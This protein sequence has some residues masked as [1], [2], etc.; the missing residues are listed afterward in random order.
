MT[1]SPEDESRARELAETG[2]TITSDL[3]GD[4]V[5]EIARLRGDNDPRKRR[6]APS[7]CESCAADFVYEVGEEC[8]HTCFSCLSKL[9]GDRR[10]S[11][12]RALD[13]RVGDLEHRLIEANS[14]SGSLE[15]DVQHLQ[16]RIEAQ[17]PAW[18]KV[19]RAKE[20]ITAALK[21]LGEAIAQ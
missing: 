6:M 17:I 4:A 19:T 13:E 10:P 18:G 1:W 21:L 7:V 12:W 3:L 8:S 2:D 20:E 15:D 16:D 11:E 14:A 5:S 9:L